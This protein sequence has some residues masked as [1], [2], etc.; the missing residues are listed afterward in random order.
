[1][2]PLL[3]ELGI[4]CPRCDAYNAANSAKCVQCSAPLG[5]ATPAE[6]APA[7]RPASTPGSSRPTPLGMPALKPGTGPAPAT[8]R[9]KLTVVRGTAGAG[10]QF[11]LAGNQVGAGR[12]K[13][14]LLFPD[15]AFVAPL[16]CTFLVKGE[17]LFVRDESSAS[18]T[19]ATVVKELLGSNTFFAVGDTLLR[20]LGPLP[21]PAPVP[22]LHY[23]APLPPT[24]LY[25]IEEILEGLRPGRTLARS[26]PT[27][28][29]GQ[30]GCEF[31][32]TTD[33]NVAPRHC[34]LTF[35]PQ[36]ATLRDLGS[37]GGTFVRLAPGTER[38]LKLGDQV[39]LGN[40]ILKVE[41][42]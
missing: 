1:M 36:G 10:S 38:E 2:N 40:E 4:V 34:E 35:N 8:A 13:G 23:G 24:P 22:V 37:P 9:F 28:A 16:H 14:L 12:S 19:F 18:G 31:L 5:V 7:A 30:A 25:L 6:A 21:A 11:R 3:A 39:R 17:K 42:A 41:A 26:G 33:P 15:D 20:Y 32:V 27:V 29:V